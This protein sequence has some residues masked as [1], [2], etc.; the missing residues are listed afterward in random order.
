MSGWKKVQD[1]VTPAWYVD[2][3]TAA[4]GSTDVSSPVIDWIPSD[5][6]F[7]VIYNTKAVATNS[8]DCDVAI[9]G[10]IDKNDTFVEIKPDLIADQAGSATAAASYVP[11]T[12]GVGMPLYKVRLDPDGDLNGAVVR[13]AVVVLGLSAADASSMGS[14]G[15]DIGGIGPDPS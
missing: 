3:T 9:D 6:T 15:A 2:I 1:G 12:T 8:Q 7:T 5:K 14:N 11:A 4:G 13:V 10:A